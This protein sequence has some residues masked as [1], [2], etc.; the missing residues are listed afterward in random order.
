M[1]ATK[2]SKPIYP[3]FLELR[4]HETYEIPKKLLN[5]AR[6]S[7]DSSATMGTASMVANT[8]NTIYLL[9]I[10]TL[11]CSFAT[12]KHKSLPASESPSPANNRDIYLAPGGKVTVCHS[13]R[14]LEVNANAIDGHLGHGD[15]LGNCP[16]PTP[17]IN[18]T[19]RDSDTCANQYAAAIS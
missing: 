6:Q 4:Y 3:R 12:P 14:D 1:V 11:L 8:R 10:A 7:F 2:M 13:G 18:S 17:P 16:T 5:L 15:T 19:D 9:A